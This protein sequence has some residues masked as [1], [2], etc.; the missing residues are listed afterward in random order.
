MALI[1]LIPVTT[2][3]YPK[4]VLPLFVWETKYRDLLRRHRLSGKALG[5]VL[6]KSTGNGTFSPYEVGTVGK[7]IAAEEGVK[8]YFKAVLRGEEKFRVNWVDYSGPIL[9]AEVEP[10]VDDEGDPGEVEELKRRVEEAFR[11]YLAI[12]EAKGV[13]PPKELVHYD[14]PVQYSYT[15]ADMLNIS[16][17]DKQKL[18]SYTST[19]QRLSAELEFLSQIVDGQ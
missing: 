3:L 8:G 5:V 15:V 18:L 14:D 10:L 1:P 17:I 19:S 4:M 12:L 7:V 2:V 13:S 11:R 6:V 16:P 9:R